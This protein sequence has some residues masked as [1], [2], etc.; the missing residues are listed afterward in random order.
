MK[1][2]KK[3]LYLILLLAELV[4]G[5]LLF[6]LDRLVKKSDHSCV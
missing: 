5:F 2:M 3:A 1:I 6:G 4:A